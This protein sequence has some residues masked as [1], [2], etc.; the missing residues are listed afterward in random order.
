MSE[1]VDNVLKDNARRFNDALNE[2]EKT[3]KR[4]SGV[5]DKSSGVL[6]KSIRGLSAGFKHAHGSVE[7]FAK[8]MSSQLV[9]IGAAGAVFGELVSS[10]FNLSKTYSKLTDAGQ[11]FNGSML[12]MAAQA[13]ASGVSLEE[14]SRSIIKNSAVATA[15]QHGTV[16]N[17]NAFGQLQ[18]S[19]RSSL[20]DV[21]QFGLS[22]SEINDATGDY[23][24]TLRL[25]GHLHTMN[26]K[27]QQVA[28]TSLITDVSKFSEATGKSR[29][30]ILQGAMSFAKNPDT[31]LLARLLT[32]EG[33][34]RF[35]E[36]TV[37]FSS[38]PGGG[39]AFKQF[40]IESVNARNTGMPI[41]TTKTGQALIEA[42]LPH[43]VALFEKFTNDQMT[44]KNPNKLE[45]MNN[46]NNSITPA[47]IANLERLGKIGA[48][49]PLLYGLADSL[50]KANEA[51]TTMPDMVTKFMLNL[52]HNF[53]E[54]TGEFRKSF[55]EGILDSL[56]S[57]NSEVAE[58]IKNAGKT[59]SKEDV[60]AANKRM[61]DELAKQKANFVKSLQEL[62]KTLGTAFGEKLKQFTD[63]LNHGGAEKLTEYASTFVT[64][65]GEFA[66]K[67][68]ELASGIE[69]LTDLSLEQ[70]ILAYIGSRVVG[71]AM[72][73]M[74]VRAG[75]AIAAAIL[76]TPIGW[77]TAVLVSLGLI[78]AANQ[79][80]LAVSDEIEQKLGW[81]SPNLFADDTGMENPFATWIDK[82]GN[83]HTK[84]E[85]IKALVE[86]NKTRDASLGGIINPNPTEEPK[87]S[88]TGFPEN[89]ETNTPKKHTEAPW[90]RYTA[91]QW[92]K[93][94]DLDVLAKKLPVNPT[95]TKPIIRETT[96]PTPP[97]SMG[98]PGLPGSADRTMYMLDHPWLE[99][100]GSKHEYREHLDNVFQLVRDSPDKALIIEALKRRYETSHGGVQPIDPKT[101]MVADVLNTDTMKKNQMIYA[102]SDT[103]TQLLRQLIDLNIPPAIAAQKSLENNN[104]GGIIAPAYVPSLPY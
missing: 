60:I 38:I 81:K 42:G 53:S 23:A 20:L 43:V 22:M 25:T 89:K 75:T 46:V 63:W 68:G 74:F 84:E 93:Y 56:V 14:F 87:P 72:T 104:L 12:T 26:S 62:G 1:D 76:G 64:K 100:P 4:S 3:Q 34:K 83:E 101:G 37:A 98:L 94:D 97:M 5:L 13:S 6:D 31:A 16:G 95:P 29:K 19:V 47:Q 40:F 7:D 11:Y 82:Q 58:D 51:A 49:S 48:V 77:I 90:P 2:I 27:E 86:Y 96:Y 17:I 65:V 73:A 32:S 41:G 39:D 44:G 28:I 55:Y 33:M 99:N 69:K 67:V 45:F 8:A 71:A 59:G 10:V 88:P 78:T 50:K 52:D 30:E 91:A 24:E 21:G 79:K 66:T 57:V 18:K 70:I 61:D 92:A 9:V 85:G 102:K 80:K 103:Q 54:I 36:A 15:L 35:T